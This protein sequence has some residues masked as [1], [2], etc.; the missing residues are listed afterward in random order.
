MALRGTRGPAVNG[1]RGGEGGAGARRQLFD[2]AY[3]GGVL[4][5][6]WVPLLVGGAVFVS[7]VMAT[8]AATAFV[9]WRYGLRK[10]RALRSHGAVVG[11]GVLWAAISSR[12]LRP[13]PATSPADMAHWPARLVR[14]EMWRSVDRAEAAVHT[15]H[16][17]GGPTADLP[18]LCRRLRQAAIALDRIL[19][20]ESE[21]AV[22]PTLAA[23][24]F[25][26]MR[27]ASD[28][29][30]AAVAS[31]G[32]ATGRRV[33]ELARDADHELLSL[34]AGLAST[35]ALLGHPDL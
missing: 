25:D 8:V 6:I 11:A 9:L 30:R 24:A 27:A 20:V 28:V 29:Q 35:R 3:T 5:S 17:L 19:R 31:A 26:V 13:R 34:D 15:A 14:K 1:H 23:Q 33:D 18:L 22:S 4:A 32:D 10:W 16:D 12:H 2:G 21:A 7:L